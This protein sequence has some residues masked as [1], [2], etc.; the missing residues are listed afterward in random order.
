MLKPLLKLV[1]IEQGDWIG[2]NG[3][4]DGKNEKTIRLYQHIL[5][6]LANIPSCEV[7]GGIISNLCSTRILRYP[8]LTGVYSTCW[9][10]LC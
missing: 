2:M 6:R 10:V 9:T 8:N 3:V 7:G 5:H 4:G 1:A